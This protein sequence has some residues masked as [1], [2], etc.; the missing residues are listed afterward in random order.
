[1]LSRWQ[2]DVHHGGVQHHHELGDSHDDQDQPAMVAF[3]GALTAD[4]GCDG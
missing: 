2:G 1:M 3:R 4:D